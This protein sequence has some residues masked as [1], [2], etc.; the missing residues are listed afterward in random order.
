MFWP[1]HTNNAKQVLVL[2]VPVM[3][4]LSDMLEA[5]LCH[6]RQNH[7]QNALYMHFTPHAVNVLDNSTT[8]GHSIAY[9]VFPQNK[10]Q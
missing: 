8:V 5:D 4:T 1:T 7:L 2:T 9:V 10:R 3:Q 6:S